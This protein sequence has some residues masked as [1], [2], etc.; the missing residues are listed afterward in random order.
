[1]WTVYGDTVLK[2]LQT[3]IKKRATAEKKKRNTYGKDKIKSSTKQTIIS[4]KDIV[5]VDCGEWF[6]VSFNDRRSCRC[7]KCKKER[8]RNQRKEYMRKKREK[9]KAS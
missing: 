6:T 2:N 9:E 5:C 3:N 8:L 4:T 7:E 1:M